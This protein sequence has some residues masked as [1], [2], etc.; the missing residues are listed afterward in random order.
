MPA[1]LLVLADAFDLVDADVGAALVPAIGKLE[2]VIGGPATRVT[3]EEGV[4]HQVMQDVRI[5]QG[6]EVWQTHKDW[7]TEARPEFGPGISERIQWTS[8]I[9][10]DE[11]SAA[12]TG[13][14]KWRKQADALLP[15]GTVLCL[16]TSIDIAPNRGQASEALEE[17]RLRLFQLLCPAGL[18]GLPQINLPLSTKEGCPLG[19]GVIGGRGTDESLL[20]LGAKISGQC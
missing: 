5:L 1:N 20:A 2:A 12:K 14:A 15:Q 18:A 4:L 10:A 3:L 19:L 9:S 8:T 6:A 11:V 16:P 17:Y 7:I 13:Q